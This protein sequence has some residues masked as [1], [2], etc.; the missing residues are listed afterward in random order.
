MANMNISITEEAYKYLKMLKGDNRSFSDV[1]LEFK[2]RGSLRKG[3][4]EA[5]LRFAGC[6]KDLNINWK[7]KERRM[8]EFRNSFN[9]RMKKTGSE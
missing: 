4:K 5:V 8:K 7:E 2:N 3:S 6:L 9:K 1:V